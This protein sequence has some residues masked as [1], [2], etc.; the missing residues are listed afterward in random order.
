MDPQAA[1]VT[2]AAS[3]DSLR[4]TD[5]TG[6]GVVGEVH[7]MV[8]QDRGTVADLTLMPKDAFQPEPTILRPDPMGRWHAGCWRRC[9]EDGGRPCAVSAGNARRAAL[10][11]KR[12][13]LRKMIADGEVTVLSPPV[14]QIGGIGDLL[15]HSVGVKMLQA[16]SGSAHLAFQS[17]PPDAAQAA[18]R[19]YHRLL[20]P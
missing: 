10:P 4:A 15:A 5:A 1:A 3:D 11:E 19:P 2:A 6:P 18:A 17:P 12:R 13:L 14:N 9:R 7:H 8:D 20:L 16:V